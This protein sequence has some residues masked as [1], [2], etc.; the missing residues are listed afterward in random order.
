MGANESLGAANLDSKGMVDRI[1]VGD[2]LTLLHTKY[3]S[4]GPHGFREEFF[5]FIVFPL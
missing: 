3:V 4:R 5:F 1:Y 2:R